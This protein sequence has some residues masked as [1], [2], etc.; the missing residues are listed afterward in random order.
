MKSAQ[1]K[2]T[3][4]LHLLKNVTVTNTS[5]KADFETVKVDT[6]GTLEPDKDDKDE[7]YVLEIKKGKYMFS[8]Y[9]GGNSDS[10]PE[11]LRCVRCAERSV[12]PELYS[13]MHK[14]SS[15]Y[16]MSRSQTEGSII[17][18]VN[19]L[20]GRE[21]K[22]YTPREEHDLNTL[23]SM[24]NIVHIES[25]SEAIALSSIVEEMMSEDTIASITYSN[26]GSSVSRV[27]SYV[28]QSLTLNGVQRCLPTFG[29]FTESHE[30]PKD[31]EICTLKILSVSCCHEY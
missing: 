17:T 16:D 19:T 27:G 13:V 18:I 6:E 8:K 14:L 2:H 5:N 25:Y 12:R 10:I 11:E 1:K 23:L 22:P 26:D 9:I 31:L 7:D 29:I 24:K 30:S 3:D 21:W 28:V 4:E 15:K 20:F